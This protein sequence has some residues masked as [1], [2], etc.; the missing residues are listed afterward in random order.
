VI[1]KPSQSKIG[2]VIKK[3]AKLRKEAG[4]FAQLFFEGDF[5]VEWEQIY[6]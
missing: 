1:E 3:I 5:L 4:A 2:R 6:I